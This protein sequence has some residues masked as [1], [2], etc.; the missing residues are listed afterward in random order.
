MHVT[1]RLLTAAVVVGSWA[2]GVSACA[3]IWGFQDGVRDSSDGDTSPSEA[4]ESATDGGDPVACA[5]ACIAAPPP[6]WSGPYA[7][8]EA[9]GGALASC[10]YGAYPVEVYDGVALPSAPAASC[11]CT[12]G[13]ATGS[14][15]EPPTITLDHGGMCSAA[16]QCA[17]VGVSLGTCVDFDP[18]CG[19]THMQVSAPT[20]L[21]GTCAASATTH[22]PDATWTASARLCS[23]RELSSGRCA[24][25]EVCA[26]PAT[27]P[28]VSCIAMAELSACPSGPYT[29]RRV[30]YGGATDTR[31]CTG[32]SCSAPS[33]SCTG[34]TVAT[35]DGA[36]CAAPSHVTWDV[37]Q[38]CTDVHGD[39]S[40]VF[41]GDVVA[42]TGA[43]T[44]LGGL[45]TGQ[46]APSHPTTICCTR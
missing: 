22:V 45:P 36:G 6:G 5:L 4:S 37:P 7:L 40:A 41:E 46:L 28:F 9:V 44:P 8:S 32:C 33:L 27:L 42:S 10:P 11:E 29:D 17:T 12:C 25:D 15:C 13:A 19:G 16:S 30:Y 38:S 3:D 26:P 43:C 1:P 24:A 2:C 23:V 18:G 21:P 20:P 31:G 39:Q 14:R 34:G 35:F